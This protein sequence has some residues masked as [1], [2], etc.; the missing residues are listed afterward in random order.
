MYSRPVARLLWC[1]PYERK[2][3]GST[4]G[5]QE[6]A[7][8]SGRGSW[9]KRGN[10]SALAVAQ[11]YGCAVVLSQQEWRSGRAAAARV[12]CALCS[13]Q[14]RADLGPAELIPR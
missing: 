12:Q 7:C 8:G 3:C 4:Q 14:S 6:L 9:H 11:W 5:Q 1:A 13:M 10:G 2:G